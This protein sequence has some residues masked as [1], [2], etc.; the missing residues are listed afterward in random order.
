MAGN[1]VKRKYLARIAEAGG[2]G[3]VLDQ[4][5]AGATVTAVAKVLG[6]S[7]PFLSRQLNRDNET[8]GAVCIARALAAYRRMAAR[9]RRA[10]SEARE[11]LE[12]GPAMHLEALR[13]AR[14]DSLAEAQ[15]HPTPATSAPNNAPLGQRA[16]HQ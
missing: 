16:G 2:I 4:L 7:R 1:P 8:A 6:M 3:W 9:P 12:R 15:P 10:G 5:L 14:L 13:R 11:W